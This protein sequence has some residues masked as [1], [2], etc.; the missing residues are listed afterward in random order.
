MGAVSLVF[1]AWC[2]IGCAPA[3]GGDLSATA[4]DDLAGISPLATAKTEA[5]T[6]FSSLP[7]ATATPRHVHHAEGAGRW[8]PAEP[9]ALLAAVQSF[10]GQW[11]VALPIKLLAVVI[12]RNTLFQRPSSQQVRSSGL[13]VWGDQEVI[14][15]QVRGHAPAA[16]ALVSAASV[17]IVV[18]PTRAAS[19]GRVRAGS[20]SIAPATS[21]SFGSV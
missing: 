8:Y 12:G 14:R 10:I 2:V 7:A 21:S 16:V 6:P 5:S 11:E 18:A 20:A 4:T 9:G 19:G 15:Q 1:A 13:W 3:I 17:P